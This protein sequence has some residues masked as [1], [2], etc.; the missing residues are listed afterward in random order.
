MVIPGLVAHG[1]ALEDA[2]DYTV[3]ACWEFIIPGQGHGHGEYRRG[4]VPASRRSG[5]PGR[6]AGRG[7]LRGDHGARATET[8]H[9]QVN[10]AGRALLQTLLLPPAPYY[11]VLMNGCLENG[12]DLSQGLTYNNFGIHGACSA[13]AADALAAVQQLVFRGQPFTPQNCCTPWKP[14]LRTTRRC[15]TCCRRRGPRS[16]T[17]MPRRTDADGAVRDARRRLRADRGERARRDRASGH[18]FGDVLRLAGARPRGHARAGRRRDR[19][20]PQGR[21]SFSANL[22]PSPGVRVPGPFSV[23][24]TFGKLDYQR[25]FNGG[26]DHDRVVVQRL[27]HPEAI[28]KVAMLVRT[29]AQLAASS[30]SSTA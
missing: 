20:W 29:F 24:Q 13:N 1:Y 17:T 15:A 10:A 6:A 28:R 21:D 19:R 12:R 25:I 11:S 8:Y 3:A 23:F 7:R 14:I 27:P 22:A 9:A 4:V 2:R 5:D 26:S 16:A 18:G 30:F